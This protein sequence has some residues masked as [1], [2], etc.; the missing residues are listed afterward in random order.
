MSIV[1]FLFKTLSHLLSLLID[2]FIAN[3][4]EGMELEGKRWEGKK[5]KIQKYIYFL[6]KSLFQIHFL[7]HRPIF[8][9]SF[10]HT[11]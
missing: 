2:Y 4:Y 5:E 9:F 6:L 1:V 10:H 8:F 11:A 3:K 7:S